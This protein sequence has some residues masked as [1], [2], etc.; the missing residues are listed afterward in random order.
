MNNRTHD[1]TGLWDTGLNQPDGEPDTEL[2]VALNGQTGLLHDRLC[3]RQNPFICEHKPEVVLLPRSKEEL[4][5]LKDDVF[6][7]YSS[8]YIRNLTK[9]VFGKYIQKVVEEEMKNGNYRKR[10]G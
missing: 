1:L 4:T 7:G 6:G 10:Q 2:C 5:Q 9:G 8:A 3:N